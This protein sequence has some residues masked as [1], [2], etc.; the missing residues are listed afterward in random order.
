MVGGGCIRQKLCI[1]IK[2]AQCIYFLPSPRF[3]IIQALQS[4]SCRLFFCLFLDL[5]HIFLIF[6]VATE[7][8]VNDFYTSLIVYCLTYFTFL[9]ISPPSSPFAFYIHSWQHITQSFHVVVCL[10]ENS[11]YLI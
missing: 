9:R 1:S 3:F 8:N 11:R 5:F 4:L 6:K 10:S 7:R 2:D